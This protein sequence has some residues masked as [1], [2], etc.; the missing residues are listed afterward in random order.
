MRLALFQPDIPQNT[1]AILRGSFFTVH[2]GSGLM[3]IE[4]AE[5]VGSHPYAVSIATGTLGFL[6]LHQ[7]G[8]FYW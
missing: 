2:A 7:L 3:T 4:K 5:T 8:F 1:G 6:V